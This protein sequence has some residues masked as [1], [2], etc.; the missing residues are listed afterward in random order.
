MIGILFSRGQGDAVVDRVANAAACAR[1]HNSCQTCVISRS[2]ANQGASLGWLSSVNSSGLCLDLD[3]G[4][5][6]LNV[7][8]SHLLRFFFFLKNWSTLLARH[9]CASEHIHL[10][11]VERIVSSLAA[12]GSDCAWPVAHVHHCIPA[13]FNM[14]FF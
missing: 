5:S 13:T 6:L 9:R 11:S 4:S 3:W 14:K 10:S 12:D 1:G 7:V 8:L 2:V